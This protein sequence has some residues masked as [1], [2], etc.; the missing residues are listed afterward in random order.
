MMGELDRRERNRSL[1]SDRRL[2]A[3]PGAIPDLRANAGIGFDEDTRRR[4]S[5]FRIPGSAPATDEH[6]ELLTGDPAAA[7]L[8]R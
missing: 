6:V 2:D 3:I 7:C 4:E 8:S 1:S 5:P